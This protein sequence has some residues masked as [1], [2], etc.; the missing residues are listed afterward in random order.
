[1]GG[2]PAYVWRDGQR[3]TPW[4]LYQVNRLDA[5]CR[6]RF[7]VGVI[8]SSGIRTYE[9]QKA[10]FLARYT[11]TPN[12]RRVYDTRW[13]NG[14][15]WYRVSAAGTVAQPGTSNHEI[16]GD[17]AAVDLRDTGRDGGLATMGSARSNWLRANAGNYD[18]VPSGFS[19]G[20]AWHYDIRN[21]WNSPP[22][23][24]PASVAAKPAPPPPPEEDENMQSVEVNGNLYGIAPEYITHYGDIRQ[25][26]ITRKVTS[27]RDELHK[28]SMDEFMSLLDGHGIP[29]EM[30]HQGK[31]YN[32]QSGKMEVNGTWSRQR[33][34]LYFQDQILKKIKDI[35]G[36]L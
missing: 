32:P 17:R 14:Q 5:D 26:D 21:I 11:S 30:V 20:E 12:G 18:M 29:R 33:E 23:A 19:F 22:A 31:V 27:V 35:E 34:I 7:G 6:R 1:M 3:L 2:T 16:Q 25:A 15:L 13:W 4:M 36:K 28:V 9:E 24:S 10:I 8:V